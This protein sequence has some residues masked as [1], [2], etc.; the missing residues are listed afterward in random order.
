MP[1]ISDVK[2]GLIKMI[3]YRNLSSVKLNGIKYKKMPILRL[4]SEKIF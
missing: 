4:T 1:K 2:D 3:L